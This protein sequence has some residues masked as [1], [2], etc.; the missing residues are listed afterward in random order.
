MAEQTKAS[1]MWLSTYGLVTVERVIGHYQM[2]LSQQDLVTALNNPSAFF[3]KLVQL[4]LLNVMTGIIRQQA[5]DLQVYAQKLYV[6]YLLS[7]E[8]VKPDS[9]P[10]GLTREELETTR[11]D[12][13]ASS[14]A[15]HEL[16]YN[17]NK[18][19]S[20]CQRTIIQAL[21]PWKKALKEGVK[22]IHTL[23]KTHKVEWSEGQV[24]ALV[25]SLFA[26]LPMDSI[27]EDPKQVQSCIETPE[28]T[29]DMDAVIS[30]FC[31]YLKPLKEAAINLIDK[32]NTLEGD[33]QSIQQQMRQYRQQ[34]QQIII[35]T[36]ELLMVLPDYQIDPEQD[37]INRELI[38]MDSDVTERTS[39]NK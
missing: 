30:S 28:G 36:N 27:D 38:H 35:T 18:Q 1:N 21:K 6:D 10:G 2:S 5:Y 16:E 39:D 19:I 37:I 31:Q 7:G 4:P 13:V 17:H 33:A 9:S 29:V 12:L 26:N 24:E 22:N 11:L 25:L 23:A 15:F 34:F 32:T 14:K 3:Y 20:A 8:T